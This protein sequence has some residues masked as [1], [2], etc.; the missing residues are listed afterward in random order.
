MDF[1]AAEKIFD[2]LSQETRLRILSLLSETDGHELSAGDISLALGVAQ[3]TLSFHFAALENAGL[4]KRQRKG[5]FVLYGLNHR[6]VD[7]IIL[8]LAKHFRH[9]E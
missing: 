7:E 3:N 1:Y 5:R 6:S 9:S 2:A 4:L 8:F